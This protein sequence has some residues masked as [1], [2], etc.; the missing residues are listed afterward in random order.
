MLEAD[1]TAARLVSLRHSSL[2]TTD[3]RPREIVLE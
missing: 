3:V 2:R 1:M